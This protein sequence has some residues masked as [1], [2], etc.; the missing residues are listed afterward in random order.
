MEKVLIFC[1]G[2]SKGNPG[3]GGWGVVTVIGE[4]IVELGGTAAHTTNNR[5][6]LTA[7]LESLRFANVSSE[8]TIE[9]YT[10][11]S[12]VI[13]GITKWVRGWK[14]NHWMTKQKKPVLNRELWET[15]L[16]V[17]EARGP[18]RWHYVGGHVGIVGNERADEI[19]DCFAAG[20]KISLYDGTAS[21]YPID[22]TNL[23][24][25]E[26]KQKEK[27]ATRTRSKAKAYSYISRVD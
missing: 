6:E 2:A 1:D 16:N 12:Y 7:A 9:V 25:N 8:S 11:S 27:S 14:E 10:D 19:A 4:K 21:T 17:V 24:L 23:D 5:M 13:N 26:T 15:L 18:I 22:V 3:P 20:K